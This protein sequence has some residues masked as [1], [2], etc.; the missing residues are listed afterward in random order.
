MSRSLFRIAAT[1][2]FLPRFQPSHTQTFFPDYSSSCYLAASLPAIP[3]RQVRIAH[4]QGFSTF[5]VKSS[6]KRVNPSTITLKRYP[7]PRDTAVAPA[8]DSSTK[9]RALSRS[10]CPKVRSSGITM[11]QI[12]EFLSPLGVTP[13][14]FGRTAAT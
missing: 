2:L 13:H 10:D 7:E 11:H 1:K 6:W 12:W 5:L 9:M 4:V 14:V 8:S 3:A